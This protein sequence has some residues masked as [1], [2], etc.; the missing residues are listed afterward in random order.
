[1]QTDVMRR[2]PAALVKVAVISSVLLSTSGCGTD[3]STDDLGTNLSDALSDSARRNDPLSLDEVTDFD[4]DRI[5][6]VCPYEGSAD[7]ERMLGFSW[8]GFPGQ[9]DDEGRSIFVFAA[10]DQVREWAYV[11]RAVADPCGDETT[12]RVVE[13]GAAR[14]VVEVPASDGSP[15]LRHQP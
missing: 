5:V 2:T 9:L 6:F 10:D 3:G 12:P 8:E 13:R 7:A 15:L 1:M 14:F 11:S 4:W